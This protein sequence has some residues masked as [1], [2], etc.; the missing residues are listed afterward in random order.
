MTYEPGAAMI[1]DE[2]VAYILRDKA[3]AYTFIPKDRNGKI[4]GGSIYVLE[5]DE[6]HETNPDEWFE[7]NVIYSGGLF[8]SS[9]GEGEIYAPEEVPEEA[10]SATYLPADRAALDASDSILE[11]FLL[12][13]RGMS[14][15]E[16]QEKFDRM[17]LNAIL[18]YGT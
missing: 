4:I 16:A 8:R 3:A 11:M 6:G 1:H 13:L 12:R 2:A 5:Y 15:K 7:Y 18:A 9:S 10:L 14:W 17:N